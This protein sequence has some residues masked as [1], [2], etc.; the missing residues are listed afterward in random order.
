MQQIFS[1]STSG[2]YQKLYIALKLEEIE[3]FE[4]FYT[5]KTLREI[6][7][8]NT[9]LPKEFPSL[10][11]KEAAAKVCHPHVSN[12]WVPTPTSK[13]KKVDW[14]LVC[15]HSAEAASKDANCCQLL[16]LG[17]CYNPGLNGKIP[18]NQ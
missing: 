12:C 13:D 16:L 9:R 14:S 17:M 4:H 11:S 2:K 8:E 10:T 3:E 15:S 6:D 18:G 1:E 7:C 5:S